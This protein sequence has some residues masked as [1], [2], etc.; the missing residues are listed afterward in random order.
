MCIF[1]LW[2]CQIQTR[3]AWHSLLL[4]ICRRI[5]TTRFSTF[6]TDF[7][8]RSRKRP[9]SFVIPRRIESDF[10]WPILQVVVSVFNRTDITGYLQCWG[11]INGEKSPNS[12]KLKTYPH[13]CSAHM[14]KTFIRS[15][16]PLK[17]DKGMCV[18]AAKLSIH[19]DFL[20]ISR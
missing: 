5:S 20:I 14:L 17:L 10:S 19:C 7:A 3:E 1:T 2:S 6:W 18:C 11:V 15:L 9:S 13:V 4:N 8:T 12:I 16:A